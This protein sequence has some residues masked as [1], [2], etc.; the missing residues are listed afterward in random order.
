MRTTENG[1]SRCYFASEGERSKRERDLSWVLCRGSLPVLML[2][3]GVDVVRQ[4]WWPVRGDGDE[5]G[6]QMG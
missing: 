3:S 5:E 2:L 4:E 1:G 6:E